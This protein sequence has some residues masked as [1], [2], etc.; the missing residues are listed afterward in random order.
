VPTFA[1]FVA[2]YLKSL[3]WTAKAPS[4]RRSDQG[5]L[6]HA[7]LPALGA[8]RLPSITPEQSWKRIA[9]AAGLPANIT[10]HSLRHGV[11]S[12]LADSGMSAMQVATALGHASSRTSER[13]CHVVGSA[14]AVLAQRAAE[15]VRPVRL[16]AMG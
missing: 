11:G 13:Y 16:R 7:L 2:G 14:R 9:A 5:R 8:L 15:L 6:D 1:E 3:G 12:A 10:L 4:T